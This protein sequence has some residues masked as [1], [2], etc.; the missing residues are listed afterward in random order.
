MEVS[1]DAIVRMALHDHPGL[2]AIRIGLFCLGAALLFGSGTL[3]NLAPLEFREVAGLYIAT[4]F[5]IW[6]VINF[7]FFRTLPTVPIMVGGVLIAGGAIVSF[8]KQ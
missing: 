5:V 1:G 7:A 4:L 2:S 8:W 3:L 6:Q